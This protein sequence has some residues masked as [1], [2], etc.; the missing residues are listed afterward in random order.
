MAFTLIDLIVGL[1]TYSRQSP[2]S[3]DTVVKPDR[4]VFKGRGQRRLHLIFFLENSPTPR[5]SKKR[6][7]GKDLK[8]IFPNFLNISGGGGRMNEWGK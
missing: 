1:G 8:K 5:F 2:T 4:R 6:E 3:R 7:K